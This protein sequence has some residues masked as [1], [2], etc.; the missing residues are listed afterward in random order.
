MRICVLLLLMSYSLFAQDQFVQ[1]DSKIKPDGKWQSN[2][3]RTIDRLQGYTSKNNFQYDKFGG[4]KGSS[5]EKTGFFHTEKKNGRWMLV[6]PEGNRYFNVGV[7]SVT[8]GASDKQKASFA[9]KFKTKSEWASQTKKILK[10]NGFNG[11]GCWSDFKSFESLADRSESPLSYT[12]LLDLMTKYGKIRGGTYKKPG[13]TG[14]PNDAIFVF[15]PAFESFCMNETLKIAQYKDDANLLGYFS[16]NELPFYPKTLDSY[17]KLPPEDS[18]YIAAEKWLTEKNINAH[19]ITDDNRKQFLAFV[20]EKYYS[21]VSS[22]IKKNDPNHLYLGSRLHSSE[23]DNEYFMRSV[24]RYVDVIAVNY[25]RSWRPSAEEMENWES[26]SSKPFI[27]SEWY[28]KAEDSGL[29]NTTGA[30]WIVKT[31]KDRGIFYQNFSI[32]LLE[33]KGCVGW[34]WFKYQDNDPD[35]K[36]AELSNIDANKGIVD[37]TY[38]LYDDLINQMQ[39]VNSAVYTLSDY[40]KQRKR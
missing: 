30:G 5:G 38:N 34:H 14:Y 24:G 28:V 21:I 16:D 7:A 19:K 25:Y 29:P 20:A 9:R 32:A 6:T 23:K 40:L 37:S 8:P 22:A 3:S 12:V 33:S 36:N 17:L 10:S 15:D 31:Q 18:G 39:P 27:I 26:W 1:V 2:P 35:D 4:V 11:L 13:H